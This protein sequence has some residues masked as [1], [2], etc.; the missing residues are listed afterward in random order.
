M[1]LH[2]KFAYFW[3]AYGAIHIQNS[4]LSVIGLLQLRHFI[5]QLLSFNFFN[6]AIKA[7]QINGA[8]GVLDKDCIITPMLL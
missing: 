6:F 4:S 8:S 5:R 1:L 2:P 3:H 7:E